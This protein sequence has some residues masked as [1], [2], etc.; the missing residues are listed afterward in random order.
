[1]SRRIDG[2]ILRAAAA[3][4]CLAAAVFLVLIALDARAWG[5]RIAGDDLRFRHRTLGAH[6]WQRTDLAPFGAARSLLGIDDDL[7]YRRGLLAFRVGRPREPLFVQAVTT[8]RI[9]AQIALEKYYNESHDARR[10]AQAAN[11]IGVLGFAAATLDAGQRATFL[12]DA[13]PSF[14]HAMQ[15]EPGNEDAYYNLELALDQLK[16]AG[17]QQAGSGQRVGG[18]GGAGL[19]NAGHGY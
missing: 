10:K 4:L 19:R 15:L 17:E 9:R 5:T 18:T 12:N 2:R 16:E 11:L 8:Q 13:I 6:L 3:V 7:L 1:V 14:E